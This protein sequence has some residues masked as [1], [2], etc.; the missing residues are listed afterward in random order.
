MTTSNREELVIIHLSVS[1]WTGRKKV[2]P[3]DLKLK[4]EDV[5]GYLTLGHKKTVDPETLSDFG[6]LKK[7]AERALHEV[8]VAMPFGTV[9]PPNLAVEAARGLTRIQQEF[10]ACREAFL[11]QYERHLEAWIEKYPEHEA[12]IRAA[13]VS[14]A[15][16]SGQLRFWFQMFKVSELE[17][18]DATEASLLTMGFREARKDLFWRLIEQACEDAKSVTN[19]LV[20]NEKSGQRTLRPLKALATK[21]RGLSFLDQRLVSMAAAIESHLEKLPKLGFLGDQDILHLRSLLRGLNDPNEVVRK[22]DAGETIWAPPASVVESELVSVD[23][24]RKEDSPAV[25]GP[26]RPVTESPAGVFV[27]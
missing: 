26:V 17:S 19:S 16:V 22:L 7:E 20:K 14:K 10:G 18:V 23:E 21:I 9:V 15:E 12:A 25:S 5:P 13:T 3:D 4:P 2:R 11:A 27:F 1:T 6:R 24:V 8:G